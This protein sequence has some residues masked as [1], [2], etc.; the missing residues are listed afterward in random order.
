MKTEVI[1]AFYKTSGK[2]YSSEEYKS[3]LVDKIDLVNEAKSKFNQTET[4]DY[5]LSMKKGD[6]WNSWLIKL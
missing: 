4:M 1:V 6:M 2:F 5:V 3:D